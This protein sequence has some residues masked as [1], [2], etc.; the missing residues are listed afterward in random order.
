MSVVENQVAPKTTKSRWYVVNVYSGLEKKFIQSLKEGA[1]KK[2]LSDFFEEFLVPTEEVV[3][4]KAGVKVIKEKQYF[5]GYILVKME[6]ND[7]VWHLVSNTPRFS[8]FLGAKGKPMPISEREVKRIMQQVEES[9]EKPRHSLVFEIGEQVRVCEGPFATFSGMV[10]EVDAEKSRVK[11]AVMIFG[12]STPVE[13]DFSQ[14][15]KM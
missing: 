5:P 4:I 10:D 8:S 1:E 13:L 7:A 9:V 11:V 3:E 15:E 12:R 2:G 6:L 14:V